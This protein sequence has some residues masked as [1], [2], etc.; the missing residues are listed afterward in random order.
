MFQ[1]TNQLLRQQKTILGPH[2]VRQPH[3]TASNRPKQR[4][5]GTDI[6]PRSEGRMQLPG[7]SPW[8]ESLKLFVK[9]NVAAD[10]GEIADKN[11]GQCRKNIGKHGKSSVIHKVSSWKVMGL[12]EASAAKRA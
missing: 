1:T 12:N 2:P 9:K 7:R 4:H 10:H 6:P 8:E 11:M 3:P 5:R